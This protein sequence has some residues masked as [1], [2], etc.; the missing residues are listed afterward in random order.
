MMYTVQC[1]LYIVHIYIR[2]CSNEQLYSRER[3]K[4]DIYMMKSLFN[5]NNSNAKGYAVCVRDSLWHRL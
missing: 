5:S 1:T 4:P 3:A 2:T